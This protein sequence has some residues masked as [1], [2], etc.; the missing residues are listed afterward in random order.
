MSEIKKLDKIAITVKSH[1]QLKK[2]LKE[3]PK[4][5]EIM[6]NSKNET[7]ALVGVRQWVLTELE[8]SPKALKF[9]ESDEGGRDLFEK[10]N[11]KDYA[12]IRLL[13]YIDNAGKKYVDLNLRGEVAVS[14]PIKL[15]W[16]AV[17]HG[18]GGAKPFF[19]ED[20]LMLFRQFSGTFKPEIPTQEIVF[21]WMER[22]PSGIDPRI[23]K[24]REEN[25][26]RIINIL[27]QKLDSGE[28][29][30]K[31]YIFNE[32]MSQEQKFLQM[33]EWWKNYKFHLHFAIRK[34][35][36]L[37]EMLGNSLD[38]DTMKVLFRAEKAGIPFFVNPYYLSLLHVRVPY[39]AI[40]ADLAIRHYIIYTEQLINEF[41]HIV[42]WEMED[43]VKPGKPN[44]A[45]WLLPSQHS[46]HRRYPEVSHINSRY[47]GEG[48]WRIVCQL[49][50][51]VRFPK[52][53]PEF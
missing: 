40:G 44:A 23:I 27:I 12:A 28:I 46:V 9:Y 45:G 34:P 30:S 8:K 16:L 47:Y 20:M 15:I 11:W 25:R 6:R 35:K 33:L 19:F 10:L 7:E 38:P 31:K 22:Y 5:E 32:G 29:K 51:N 41:G 26:D 36:L 3:N 17:N 13:D 48:L 24:L 49:P 52:W 18:T 50:E 43:E 21:D 14:N 53:K 4:F 2:L 37:N 42:A 39:F 1:K